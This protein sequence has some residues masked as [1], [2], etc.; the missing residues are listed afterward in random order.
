MDHMVNDFIEIFKNM[1]YE[2]LFRNT[3]KT[4][5]NLDEICSKII[6][7]TKDILNDDLIKRQKLLS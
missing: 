5:Y 6:D 7:E 1:L 3:Y 4:L 2:F